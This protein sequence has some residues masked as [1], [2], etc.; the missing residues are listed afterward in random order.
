LNILGVIHRYLSIKATPAAE[1]A[2][3]YPPR[4]ILF[5]GK[6]A[7]GYWMAKL[8]IRLIVN[9]GKV[10]NNDPDTKGLLT[11]L[12]LPDYSVSRE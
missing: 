1:R 10:V 3:K 5:A 2:T 12:F 6:A 9:V 8:I 11:V 7:P 4:V